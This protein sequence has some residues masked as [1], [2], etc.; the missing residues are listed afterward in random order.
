[1]LFG[2]NMVPKETTGI[3]ASC[4]SLLKTQPSTLSLR[5]WWEQVTVET[6]V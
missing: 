6:L 3:R 2:T 4:Q 1:M 5:V